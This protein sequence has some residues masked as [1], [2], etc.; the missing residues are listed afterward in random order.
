MPSFS[1][2]SLLAGI[3]LVQLGGP[4][5][6]ADPCAPPVTNQVACENTK[7]GDP[8]SD[9]QINGVGD[10]SIQGFATS[11]SVNLGQTVN[12]KIK[13]PASS[14]HI[15]IL[16]LG[17]YNGDGARKIASNIQPSA[18]LPQT[19]PACQTTS[20]TGLVDCG[21]WKVSASWTVPNNAVSGLYIAHLVRNDTGGESQIFFVVRDDSSH[22]DVVL[23]T[24]DATWQAY[25]AYGGNSLYSCTVSCPPGNPGGY[26]A[27]YAVSYNRPFDG[28]LATDN[29]MSDPF[30]SEY[31]MIRFL[32]R[33]GYDLSYVAQKDVD[34][35]GT[36]L[37]NHKT[38]ISSG[39]DEYWAAGER[40]SVEAA[41]NAGVNLAFFSGNE[42]FWKTRWTP[43]SA[44]GTSTPYRT[45]VDYKDTHFDAPVDPSYPPV[46]TPTWRDPRY[47]PPGD[48]GR[49]ENSLSGQIFL[50]NAG[51]SDIKVPS[52]FS[53]LR[54]WRNTAV[55]TLTSGQTLTLGAGTGTLGYEW[56]V[57]PDN[58]FRP[59]GRFP[60]SSTT[61]S[62]LQTFTDY[63]TGVADNTTASHSL[64]LYRAPS[65]ALVFGAG[66]V[67]WSWGLDIT[68]AWNSGATNPD[69][70]HTDANMQQATVNLLADMG[71]QPATLQ[72]GLVGTP[73][74]TDTTAPTAAISSPSSGAS[75]TDGNTVTVSGTAA[76]T[77]GGNVAAVEVSTDGGSTWHTANGTSSWTYS[78][79]VH[80]GPSTTVKA[81]AID[82]SGNI[83]NATAGTPVTVNC[84]CT[85][86]G[87]TV[88][89][90]TD[91]GDNGSLEV[92]VKF[93]S[94]LPG[95]ISGVRFYKSAKNTG[96]HVGSLWKADG[97]LLA[98][99]TFSGETAS[100]WQKVNFSS[101]VTIQPN[102]TY[103]AGYF[104]PNG[105]YSAQEWALNH[106][107]ATGPDNL[108]AP[109]LH[110]LPDSSSGGNGLYQYDSSPVF[111]TNTYQ[112]ENY[113]VDVQFNPST[114]AQ[115]PGQVT[116]V[117][118]TAGVGQATVNWTPPANDGGSAITSYRITPYIGAN[119]QTPTTVSAPASSKTITGLTG[120]TTYTF[121]VTAINSVGPG[122][123]SAPSNATT[124]TTSPGAPTGVSATAGVGAGDRQLDA[125][126]Q[127]RRQRDHQLPDHPLHRRQRPD[128]DHGQRPGDLEDDHRPHRRHDLHLH[129][130]RDQQRRAGAGVGALE[131]HHPYDVARGADGGER[132]RR[133]RSRRPSTGRRR[134]TTAAARSP[135]TGSPPTSA[136][137][138]RR[139][140][141]SAP[142][143][144]RRRS[145]ASPAARPTPSR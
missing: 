70:T 63:G 130:D 12:F 4:A 7:P 99:A 82:D 43:S 55:S 110:V 59:A 58:G 8:P 71:A 136:P 113:W 97:T 64:S 101:P 72:S 145:P 73:K 3:V 10:S 129:G 68:N 123:E 77:G 19:Q 80:G 91:S 96:T 93:R 105:H 108:D 66:T 144:L 116:N 92:G 14:Y 84:P 50:V 74:S 20:S 142:R 11:M 127:R 47:S 95:T 24:A 1:L 38:F 89:G 40:Q 46:T 121:T 33:N 53:K 94:D 85:V 26:K 30:Y 128:A 61:V 42:L 29:G 54:F 112:S 87:G 34:S 104:A 79:N 18:S 22:S 6:A 37:Q 86:F 122:Q 107:P 125:A 41:R 143:R 126:G 138:P 44:D 35:N 28:T 137:T 2:A 117:S 56:D 62:G 119:A 9:W 106:P 103:V 31:Q 118:A 102:T 67:Q 69:A 124:P 83:G 76:D 100:G 45:L 120:G 132:H 81:R 133:S 16:R 21:N 141:R 111:P 98:Q 48:A 39:H 60:L 51:T 49:P 114:P 25:N 75:L 78:W 65:G 15:D 139:R 140:P 115:A 134:P 27:A 57:D 5:S 88:P 109:P 131:R 13:T 17:Y 135:A 23:K 32:E 36:L 90:T 52:T